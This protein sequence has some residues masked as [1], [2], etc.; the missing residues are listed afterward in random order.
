MG[1]DAHNVPD[2]LDHAGH[3]LATAGAAGPNR[4]SF[5]ECSLNAV[6]DLHGLDWDDAL[7]TGESEIDRQHKALVSDMN[8]IARELNAQVDL[9]RLQGSITRFMAHL[10]EHFETEEA[11]MEACGFIGARA[12]RREHGDLLDSVNWLMMAEPRQAA[13]LC[14]RCL[15]DWVQSH[16]V[17]YDRALAHEMRTDWVD[18]QARFDFSRPVP[19]PPARRKERPTYP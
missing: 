17:Q 19:V 7:L 12:H 14:A 6:L 2:L 3:A 13:G 9:Q 10:R 15:H 4:F 1:I 11:F 8:A 16:A 5:A 18:A